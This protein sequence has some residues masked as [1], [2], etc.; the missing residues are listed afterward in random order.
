MKTWIRSVLKSELGETAVFAGQIEDGLIHETYEIRFQ[1]TSY[2]LQVAVGNEKHEDALAR[3]L[4][5]YRFLQDTE[6]PVPEAVT[7]EVK[8]V[9]GRKYVLVEKL[10]GS[11]G[12]LDISPGRVHNAGRYLAMIHDVRWFEKAG[13]IQFS[14]QELSTREFQEGSLG[15]WRYKKIQ[16]SVDLMQAAGLEVVGKRVERLFSRELFGRQDGFQAVLCHNDYTPDNVLFR[17]NE[18]TGVVDFDRAHAGDRYRDIVKAANGFWMHNPCADWNIREA[19]YTGYQ[20][21]IELSRT[22]DENEPQYRVETLTNTVGGM[23][24]LDE[25]SNYEKEF[26]SKRLLKAIDRI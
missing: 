22:F 26:Y 2:V 13:R 5:C 14:E 4:S 7:D 9:D 21:V 15:Q 8:E 6:I 19:F 20:D 12:E 1:E 3:G 25:F 11:S 23:L 17:D 24:E 16:D 18:V 10:P